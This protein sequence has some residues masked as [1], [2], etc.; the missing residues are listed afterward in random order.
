MATLLVLRF[1]LTAAVTLVHLLGLSIG[2]AEFGAVDLQCTI[3]HSTWDCTLTLPRYMP[4][5]QTGKVIGE[6]R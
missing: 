1:T 3:S 5:A 6:R 4:P 2:T